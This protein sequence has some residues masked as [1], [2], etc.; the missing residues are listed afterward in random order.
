VATE[1]HVRDLFYH[2][3]ALAATT[4]CAPGRTGIRLENQSRYR[5]SSVSICLPFL[6]HS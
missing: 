2:E 5:Q 1:R 6:I 3:P 4:F